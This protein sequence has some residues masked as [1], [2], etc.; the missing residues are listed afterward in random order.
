MELTSDRRGRCAQREKQ[1]D[2][3]KEEDS[4]N[5]VDVELAI[6]IVIYKLGPLI[7]MPAAGGL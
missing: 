4:M 7:L 5:V 2:D 6:Y 3:K 1:R